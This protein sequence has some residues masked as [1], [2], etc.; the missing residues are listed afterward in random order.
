MDFLF[1]NPALLFGLAAVVICGAAICAWHFWGGNISKR[2]KGAEKMPAL[3]IKQHQLVGDKLE[4][5][6]NRYLVI[7][8]PGQGWFLDGI[9]RDAEGKVVG[10]VLTF[11]SCIPQFPGRNIDLERICKKIE[12]NDP[13]TCFPRCVA[14]IE[15]MHRETSH[16]P[17]EEWL[18]IG[19]L[20][21]VLG[22]MAI[23][24]IFLLPQLKNVF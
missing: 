6:S 21:V 19:A 1:E 13:Y 11:D 23:A 5:D 15:K 22:I 9:Q 7:D 20:A 14:D 2:L 24:L 18:G 17:L 10:V 12:E 16:S 3:F 8:K 4:I